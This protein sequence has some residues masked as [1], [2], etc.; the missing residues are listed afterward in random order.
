MTHSISPT[1]ISVAKLNQVYM[2]MLSKFREY[3]YRASLIPQHREG[4][5]LTGDSYLRIIAPSGLIFELLTTEWN[6]DSILCG[7]EC[8]QDDLRSFARLVDGLQSSDF[9]AE[10]TKAAS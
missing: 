7:I 6:Q 10:T 3:G 1:N 2:P 5:K 4:L 9:T 8:L